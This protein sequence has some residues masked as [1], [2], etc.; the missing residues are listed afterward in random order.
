MAPHVV[1]S[2]KTCPHAGCEQR[3]QAIDFRLEALGRSVHDHLVRAWWEDTGFVGRCPRCKG[4]VH[5]TIQSKRAVSA[6][7]AA[8]LPH[9]PDDWHEVAIIL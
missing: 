4:W 5:F 1:Y 6:E 8:R 2:E 3:M 9:L 7:D